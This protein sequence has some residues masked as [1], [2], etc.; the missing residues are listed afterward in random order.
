MHKSIF[1]SLQLASANI[2]VDHNSVD[3]GYINSF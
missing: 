2:G 1:I 3:I